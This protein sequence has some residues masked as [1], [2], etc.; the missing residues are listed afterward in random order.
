MVAGC[1]GA[2]CPILRVFEVWS[3]DFDTRDPNLVV[4]IS[5]CFFQGY[6]V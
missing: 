2:L 3:L 1:G 4:S 6:S 5:P